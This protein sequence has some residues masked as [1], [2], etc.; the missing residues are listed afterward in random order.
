[1]RGSKRRRVGAGISSTAATSTAFCTA[2]S[3]LIASGRHELG[4]GRKGNDVSA[5]G[6]LAGGSSSPKKTAA[7]ASSSSV[8]GKKTCWP[9]N[10]SKSLHG[11][12]GKAAPPRTT[13]PKATASISLGSIDWSQC[14][15]HQFAPPQPP[16]TNAE[17]K[18]EKPRTRNT[19]RSN[20]VP[21]IH[22]RPTCWSP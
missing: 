14:R 7:I 20:I 4:A 16:P 15:N 8:M 17:L 9:S 1:M 6:F 11:T 12:G 21:Y 3:P 13:S 18:A 2:I 22:V 19:K 5:F 10:S